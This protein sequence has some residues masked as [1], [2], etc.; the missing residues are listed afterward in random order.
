MNLPIITKSFSIVEVTDYF[1]ESARY[2]TCIDGMSVTRGFMSTNTNG[3]YFNDELHSLLNE[4]DTTDYAEGAEI[5][6]Q[7]FNLPE[8]NDICVVS[9]MTED[10][11]YAIGIEE[12]LLNEKN[13]NINEPIPLQLVKMCIAQ[14][15][16]EKSADTIKGV[17]GEASNM[18]KD[19]V[20]AETVSYEPVGG[21][22]HEVGDS[23]DEVN[24][25]KENESKEDYVQIQ[26]RSSNEKKESEEMAGNDLSVSLLK[27]IDARL[28]DKIIPILFSIDK[29]VNDQGKLLSSSIQ[30][31][32]PVEQEVSS[33]AEVVLPMEPKLESGDAYFEV[34]ADKLMDTIDL[35]FEDKNTAVLLEVFG[36]MFKIHGMDTFGQHPLD[37]MLAN[38]LSM[39]EEVDSRG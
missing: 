26:T 13:S 28:V 5:L 12:G 19:R 20:S 34:I 25:G 30:K 1:E 39:L 7:F 11:L 32:E 36:C 3:V 37:N 18:V 15:A 22:N 29:Q 4:C 31:E 24:T 27:G 16:M 17:D 6:R 33:S 21:V 38:I 23:V 8:V 35:D 10:R 9:E 2:V 14:L